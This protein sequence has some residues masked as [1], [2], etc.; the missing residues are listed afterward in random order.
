M[1]LQFGSKH[2]QS[3]W[4]VYCAWATLLTGALFL[5]GCGG[6]K[7][8]EYRELTT[9]DLKKEEEKIKEAEHDHDHDHGPNGGHLIELGEEEY[10]AEVA[11]DTSSRKLTVYILGADAKSPLPIASDGVVFEL[12]EGKDELELAITAAPL[13]GEPEGKSSRFEVA[14]D[15]VPEHIKSEEN[16]E[17]HLH[18]TIE[19]KEFEGELHHEE[20]H[21]HN[22]EHE[23]DE[24]DEHADEVK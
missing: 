1:S 15:T 7:D 18:I 24:K 17:G 11:F 8:G 4:C 13:E 6:N 10:H 12:E 21:D 19:G 3:A 20:D 2:G 22:D 16:L 5:A 14:G 23:H 9:D